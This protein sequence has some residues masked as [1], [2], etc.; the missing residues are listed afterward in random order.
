MAAVA[1]VVADGVV[2]AMPVPD[3]LGDP[4]FVGVDVVVVPPE[5]EDPAVDVGVL[6]AGVGVGVLAAGV[7]AGVLVG[8]VVTI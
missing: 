2:V 7:G 6:A 3:P 5:D 8:A 1:D 4:A